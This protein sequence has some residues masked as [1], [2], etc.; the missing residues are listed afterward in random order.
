VIMTV[1]QAAHK[2]CPLM[3]MRTGLVSHEHVMCHGPSCMLWEFK[4]FPPGHEAEGDRVGYCTLGT[5][6]KWTE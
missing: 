2:I 1:K 4:V 3:S 5:P 6:R